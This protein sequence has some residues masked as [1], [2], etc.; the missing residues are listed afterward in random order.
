MSSTLG[1]EKCLFLRDVCLTKCP[2]SRIGRRSFQK[3]QIR[4]A[5]QFGIQFFLFP[6]SIL[7]CDRR[8]IRRRRNE[9][10]HVS[11][12]GKNS[13]AA[14]HS[15]SIEPGV[16]EACLDI[17]ESTRNKNPKFFGRKCK[18]RPSSNIRCA[19]TVR[20]TPVPAAASTLPALRFACEMCAGK[21]RRPGKCAQAVPR[22]F[23]RT[24]SACRQN[25]PQAEGVRARCVKPCAHARARN[26]KIIPA[27]ND[28]Y[29]LK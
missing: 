1:L 2:D 28:H 10:R 19:R 4:S 29:F 26:G 23:L 21:T 8:I 12:H 27:C 17:A 25:A 11:S 15:K 13:W 7:L 5:G 20:A 18:H 22:R 9:R 6:S 16:A 3:V 24:P 14:T